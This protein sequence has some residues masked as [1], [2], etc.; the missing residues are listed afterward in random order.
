MA[1]RPNIQGYLGPL[2]GGGRSV[3]SDHGSGDDGSPRPC[4]AFGELE[5]VKALDVEVDPADVLALLGPNGAG[6]DGTHQPDEVRSRIGLVFRFQ[7]RR[8][9][10][11]N[12]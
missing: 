8:L 1:G 3:T 2:S 11:A 7:A 6:F 5:V 10:K 12:E 9:M 4:K